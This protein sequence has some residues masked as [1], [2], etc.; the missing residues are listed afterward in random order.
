MTKVT[1]LRSP[2]RRLFRR[3]RSI[4]PLTIRQR[5]LLYFVLAALAGLACAGVDYSVNANLMNCDVACENADSAAVSLGCSGKTFVNGK[6]QVVNCIKP[7]N[8]V[9]TPI[10]NCP[11]GKTNAGKPWTPDDCKSQ[12]LT[13]GCSNVTVYSFGCYG[14]DC[15]DQRCGR[16]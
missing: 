2:L 8:A 5:I 11:F 1:G 13:A 14:Y 10:T 15:K 16:H 4:W 6:C 7:C 3:V 9:V 12:G